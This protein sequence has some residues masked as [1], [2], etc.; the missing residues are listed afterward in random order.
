M[1]VDKWMF[2]KIGVG[3]TKKYPFLG[4]FSIVNHPFW[5]TPIFGNTQIVVSRG[6]IDETS[7]RICSYR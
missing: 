4:G 2:P 5:G 7:S 6:G 1:S 3:P